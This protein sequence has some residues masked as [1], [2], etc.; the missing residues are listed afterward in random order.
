MP[1]TRRLDE[2]AEHGDPTSKEAA[3]TL[4]R[5]LKR[6]YELLRDK[7][8]S[9]TYEMRAGVFRKIVPKSYY[10]AEAQKAQKFWALVSYEVLSV[11]FRSF[12]GR[13]NIDEAILICKFT[14]LPGRHVSY[15]T[16]FWHK[17]DGVWKCLSAGPRKLSIFNGTTPPMIDWK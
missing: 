16:V 10:L 17:E 2:S 11:E 6:F 1:I 13:T 8:W 5:D 15:S 4:A 14:E 9:E 3:S 12:Q 7:K